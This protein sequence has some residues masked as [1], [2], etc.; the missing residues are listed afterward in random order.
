MLTFATT[1]YCP[2][3]VPQLIAVK[4]ISESTWER[5]R[6]VWQ[7]DC[8]R[9]HL[10]RKRAKTKQDGSTV[11]IGDKDVD[12]VHGTEIGTKDVEM[13]E[14]PVVPNPIASNEG[15]GEIAGTQ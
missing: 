8:D 5:K 3:V 14:P 6:P 13:H 2:F 10:P 7:G 9:E 15:S 4:G 12:S 1:R 11:G